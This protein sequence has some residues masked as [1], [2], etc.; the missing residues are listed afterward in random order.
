MTAKRTPAQRVLFYIRLGYSI[1]IG[2]SLLA[3]MIYGIAMLYTNRHH[4]WFWF[5][6]LSVA[7][8]SAAHILGLFKKKKQPK[9]AG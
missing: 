6:V 5:I 7:A 9:Q 3:A 1:V 4:G 2:L 8:E